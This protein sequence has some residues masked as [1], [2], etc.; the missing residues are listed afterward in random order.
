MGG[1]I[2]LIQENDQLVEMTEQAFDSVE[3]L[4]DLLETYPVLLA[5]DQIDRATPRRWLVITREYTNNLEDW[6][7]EQWSLNRLFLDR[8]GILTLVAVQRFDDALMRQEAIGQMLEYAANLALYWPL[9]TI[10]EHF[11]TNCK[12]SGRDPE[13]VF[14]E[15]LGVEAE[16]ES[17]WNKVKTNLQVGKVRLMFVSEE[18]TVQLRRVLE[19]LN[20]KLDPVE[21]LAVEIKQYVSEDGLKTL[22]PR[23]MGKTIEAQPKKT[24]TTLERRRWDEISF[25]EE[26]TSRHEGE[27]AQIARKIH[28]WA[29]THVPPIEVQWGTG[30]T[31]GG[32]GV[33]VK[34][35]QDLTADLFNVSINGDLQISSSHYAAL[36][37]FTTT[38]TWNELRKRFSSIGLSLPVDPTE[39][40]LPTFQLST[41]QQD[42]LALARVIE[43]FDWVV[44]EL[45]GKSTQA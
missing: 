16:E 26:Y 13:Q 19:F 23:I 27:E 20:E 6:D 11:E 36:P 8:D 10:L 28:Q 30:E 39:K 3:R 32:Y 40:R 37:P 15:F 18:I 41:L 22:V 44:D 17:F 34:I 38:K 43:V 31:Y 2:Y 33:L 29:K 7:D 12:Q 5:G 25:F 1:G 21:V 45:S 24:S 35:T 42:D 4:Q 9:E 14:A